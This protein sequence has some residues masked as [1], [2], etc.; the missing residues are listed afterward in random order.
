MRQHCCLFTGRCP[1]RVPFATRQQ[2]RVYPLCRRKRPL[3]ASVPRSSD[4]TGVSFTPA[5]PLESLGSSREASSLFRVND[6]KH[7]PAA[8]KARAA[9]KSALLMWF[10]DQAGVGALSRRFV[11]VGCCATARRITDY[12]GSP[13]SAPNRSARRRRCQFRRRDW[14]RRSPRR[15]SPAVPCPTRDWW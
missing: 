15:R 8:A 12:C 7:E 11:L 5:S 9:L 3:V 1:Q 10:R 14:R 2:V 13:R 4:S 6:S